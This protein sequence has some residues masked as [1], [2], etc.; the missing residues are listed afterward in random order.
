[1]TSMS[2]SLK[3]SGNIYHWQLFRAN[4]SNQKKYDNIDFS[5]RGLAC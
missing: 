2:F 4:G 3:G 1:M 5:E